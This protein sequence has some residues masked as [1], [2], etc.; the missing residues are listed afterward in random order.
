M[1]IKLS[2]SILASDY[3]ALREN[4]SMV[5]NAGADYLHIDVMDGHFV[6]NITIG[7]PVVSCLRKSSGLVFDCHLMISDPDRYIDDFARAGADI[8]TVHAEAAAH[9]QR[10]LSYIR[11]LGLKAGVALNPATDISC[12]NYVLDD[13]DMILVM[14]VNP[15]FGGQKFIPAMTR[16][17]RDTRAL[18]S[19]R[20]ADIQVDGGITLANLKEIT[21]AGA[22]VIVAGS[23]V[24]RADDPAKAVRQF[25][26]LE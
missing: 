26:G 13:V 3:G 1:S 11:S 21:D 15:G 22:N 5:E 16:K 25:K 18:L 19:G 20:D 9:L 23:A 8:I 4:I 12:L 6:P 24:F 7:P 17:V 10:T 14:T 2:P